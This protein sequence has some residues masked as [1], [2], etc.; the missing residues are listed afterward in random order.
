MDG[1]ALNY[2]VDNTGKIDYYSSEGADLLTHTR[3]SGGGEE[4]NC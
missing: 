4:N 1:S 2:H 3:G